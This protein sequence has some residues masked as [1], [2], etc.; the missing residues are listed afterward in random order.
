ME[1][2]K[3]HSNLDSDQLK[4]VTFNVNG[5]PSKVDE[6]K[7]FLLKKDIAVALLQETWLK[8]SVK[9]NIGGFRTFR[10]DRRGKKGGGV[11]ILVRNCFAA[12]PIDFKT[13]TQLEVVGIETLING[14]PTQLVSAYNP[15]DNKV[16]DEDLNEITKGDRVLIGGDWNAKHYAWNSRRCCPEGKTITKWANTRP[17]VVIRGPEDVTSVPARGRGDVID[18]WISKNVALEKVFTMHQLDS[19]HFPVMAKI[20]STWNASHATIS[21]T[22]WMKFA[23]LTSKLEFNS[24]SIKQGEVNAA[25][26]KFTK[27]IQKALEMCRFK[28]SKKPINHLGLSGEDKELL[29][30]KY[31]A[32]RQ[33][34]IQ[35]TSKV[36]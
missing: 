9:F 19:D 26:E 15:P 25:A 2:S 20:K 14:K 7:I 32:R 13:S 18:F 8:D 33:N 22:N 21:K 31:Q 6:L 3:R 27:D 35:T 12:R 28:V 29:E 10:S 11:A 24:A 30:A 16:N 4:I 17:E 1:S 23:Y 36:S 34:Q 5:A